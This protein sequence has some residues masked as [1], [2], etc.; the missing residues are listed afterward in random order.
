[1]L[2]QSKITLLGRLGNDAEMR[3]T[4]NG[5]AVM[6]LSV[7]V[8][9]RTGPE[10]KQT[11]WYRVNVWEKLAETLNNLAMSKGDPV[12]VEGDNLYIREYEAND[13]SR[14]TS[15]EMTGRSVITLREKNDSGAPAG[16]YG[17]A[18]VGNAPVGTGAS[19]YTEPDDLP[20]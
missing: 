17:N 15:L 14:R 13:G 7:A 2:T 11:V 4:N 20:F 6:S 19:G 16:N 12:Y 1:M 5:K 10:E 8:D 3:Y 9:R 18:P